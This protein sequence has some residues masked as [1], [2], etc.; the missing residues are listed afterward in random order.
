MLRSMPFTR[1]LGGG[2]FKSTSVWEEEN[3][4]KARNF[5]RAGSFDR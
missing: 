3:S 4:F 1:S 2:A 5:K